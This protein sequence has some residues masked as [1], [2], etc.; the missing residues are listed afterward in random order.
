ME[1]YEVLRSTFSET[2][3]P[4]GTVTRSLETLR[5]NA[6]VQKHEYY[7]HNTRVAQTT[8]LAS[9]AN[10]KPTPPTRDEIQDN[11]TS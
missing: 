7:S 1:T 10:S 11:N 4:L 5:F 9:H 6:E 8:H 2:T 3:R